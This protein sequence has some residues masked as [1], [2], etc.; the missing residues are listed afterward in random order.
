[1]ESMWLLVT[2]HVPCSPPLCGLALAWGPRVG[3]TMENNRPR[4]VTCRPQSDPS[5]RPN[6]AHHYLPSLDFLSLSLPLTLS[7][8]PEL[9]VL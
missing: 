8:T 4:L 3:G 5:S 7:R 2:L 1:M 6:S 9:Q